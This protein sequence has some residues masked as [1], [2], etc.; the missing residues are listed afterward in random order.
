MPMTYDE[1]NFHRERLYRVLNGNRALVG[2]GVH[3]H[4]SV[5]LAKPLDYSGI[6]AEQYAATV[7]QGHELAF[8]RGRDAAAAA[9]AALAALCADEEE[10]EDADDAAEI[11]GD[12]ED[13]DAE[14]AE[15]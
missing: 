15:A 5:I 13:G 6:T 3:T 1:A 8:D 11:S 10:A 2:L 12:S 7:F 14:N 4:L 9:E